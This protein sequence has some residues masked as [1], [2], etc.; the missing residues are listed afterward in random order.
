MHRK[1][2]AISETDGAVPYREAAQALCAA[3]AAMNL[4]EVPRVASIALNLVKHWPDDT[5]LLEPLF[6][7]S[8]RKVDSVWEQRFEESF[9]TTLAATHDPDALYPLFEKC[10]RIGRP[11]LAWELH[12]R[13]AA[14][15]PDYPGLLLNASANA[16]KWFLFRRRWVGM[17]AAASTE[18]MDL[19]SAQR[20]AGSLPLWRNTA[21]VVPLGA[22][23]APARTVEERKQLLALALDEFKR[24]EAADALTLPMRYQFVAALERAR[25]I[26]GARRRLEAIAEDFPQEAAGTRIALSEIYERAGD[27]EQVYETLRGHTD[28]ADQEVELA[29]MLRLCEAQVNLRLGLAALHTARRALAAFPTSSQAVEMLASTVAR[30]DS[31]EEALLVLQK[32]RVRS[33]RTLTMLEAVALHRSQRFTESR[34]LCRAALLTPLPVR[35][36]TIQRPYLPPAEVT[37]LWHVLATPSEKDFARHAAALE[38]MEDHV[39]TPF[40]RHLRDIWLRCYHADAGDG[41]ADA[42]RWTEGGRD[43]V[44]KAVLLHQLT[45]LLCRKQKFENAR[46]AAGE[47]VVHL[48]ESPQLW[49]WVVSLAGPDLETVAEARAACPADSET[50]LAELVIRTQVAAGMVTQEGTATSRWE[51][52]ER[53]PAEVI[54]DDV[55][56]WVRRYVDAALQSETISVAALTRAASY[57]QRGGYTELSVQ[58]GLAVGDR[59][60]G[61]LPAYVQ[62]LRSAIELQDKQKALRFT[63]QAI[64]ASLRPPA[65]FYEKLVGLKSAVDPV[66]SDDEMVEAL[67]VLRREDPLN[68]LWAQMLG[69]V[70]FQRGGWEVVDALHQ[71]TA[72]LEYGA[73][74]RTPYLVGAE[75]ARLLDRI[76]RA[77]DLLYQGRR[78]YPEDTEILNNLVYT[79]A[80]TPETIETAL[81]L[82]PA[83]LAKARAQRDPLILDTA[84]AVYAQSGLLD[85]AERTVRQ[86]LQMVEPGSRSWYRAST[87]EVEI[88][89]LRGNAEA[90][91]DRFRELIRQSSRMQEEDIQA[92]TR[93]LREAEERVAADHRPPPPSAIRL[94]EEDDAED[95]LR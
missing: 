70:R 57:L 34:R 7:L 54:P 14:L 69:F 91:A 35:S 28:L 88:V 90:A 50:W 47:A 58:I 84:S 37:I 23:L 1:W 15:D 12:N 29:A 68:P 56:D 83:L 19:R 89:L 71:M 16:R 59:A 82:L 30:Y 31:P 33:T 9:R 81:D 52:K 87:R 93:L 66:D 2:D 72:A 79:L 5:R 36:A 41:T 73:T 48:P 95:G 27:W 44:E 43:R 18:L 40:F 10:F 51:D 80:M 21:A 3:E 39:T 26:D 42:A 74:N 62:G 75:A 32:P 46:Q 55:S 17:P 77:T 20:W 45:L 67:K 38:A 85:D 86:I 76:D 78:L 4:N 53:K 92:V 25:D 11:D 13:I 61:L 60:R 24:R 65:I 22:T 94:G 8:S 6:F 64:E 49:R 63:Q